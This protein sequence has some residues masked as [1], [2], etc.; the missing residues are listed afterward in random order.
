MH[1]RWSRV[2]AGTQ[3]PH[4]EQDTNPDVDPCFLGSRSGHFWR[5]DLDPFCTCQMRTLFGSGQIYILLRGQNQEPFGYQICTNCLGPDT[6]LFWMINLEP[7]LVM[8]VHFWAP[9]LDLF[10]GAKNGSH[11]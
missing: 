1:R 2:A 7:Y 4:R 8:F 9:D 11:R 5:L 10:L 3:Q 6:N